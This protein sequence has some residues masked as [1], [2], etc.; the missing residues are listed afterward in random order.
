MNPNDL[1][2]TAWGCRPDEFTT[3]KEQG[4]ETLTW[5]EREGGLQIIRVSSQ[6]HRPKF[7]IADKIK[8]AGFLPLIP[9][10]QIYTGKEDKGI[11][12][13]DYNGRKGIKQL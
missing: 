2:S 13:Y 5:R 12:L 10:K 3:T 6:E 8:M 9:A 4:T 7:Q 1:R 11:F